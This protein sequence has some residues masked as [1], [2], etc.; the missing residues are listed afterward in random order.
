MNL[1]LNAQYTQEVQRRFIF[2]TRHSYSLS[3]KL[4]ADLKSSI[5]ILFSL[6]HAHLFFMLAQGHNLI[7]LQSSWQLMRNK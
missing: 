3:L 4:Q 7:H 6:D 5:L 2:H 1:P